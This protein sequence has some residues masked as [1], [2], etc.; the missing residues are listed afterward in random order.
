[1]Y[2]LVKGDKYMAN[3][4]NFPSNVNL[5]TNIK[6]AYVFKEYREATW[7]AYMLNMEVENYGYEQINQKNKRMGNRKRIG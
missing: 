4:K 3:D 7:I 1:M 5:T 6:D 2:I